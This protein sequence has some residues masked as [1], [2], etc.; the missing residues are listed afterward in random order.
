MGWAV[1]LDKSAFQGREA[2]VA[3]KERARR[4]IV[5]LVVDTPED[6]DIAEL[7]GAVVLDGDEEVGRITM[8]VTSP[9]LDG[10]T[11]ALARIA[12]GHAARG[13]RLIVRGPDGG[14]GAEI[15]P[16][17]VYDPQRLRVRS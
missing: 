14:V 3:L 7:E 5:S 15:V 4:T 1:D 11:L 2:L 9:H 13:S 17:P 6:A 8:A 12:K 16:T 10:A